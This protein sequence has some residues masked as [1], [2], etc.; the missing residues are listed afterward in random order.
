M[1]GIIKMKLFSRIFTFILLAAVTVLAQNE[2]NIAFSTKSG[3]YVR[4]GQKI[5]FINNAGA[6]TPA[7]YKVERS[8]TGENNWKEIATVTSP[9]NEKEFAGSLEEW[10]SYFSGFDF[11][12]KSGD[13][14]KRITTHKLLDSLYFQANVPAVALACGAAYLDKDADENTNYTYKVSALDNNKQVISSMLSNSVK[15]PLVPQFNEIVF[16]TKIKTSD[17]MFLQWSTLEGNSPAGFKVVRTDMNDGTSGEVNVVKGFSSSSGKLMMNVKDTLLKEDVVYGY[18]LVPIDL[19][20]NEGSHTQ[21]VF[22]GNYNFSKVFIS[23]LNAVSADTLFSINLSWKTENKKLAQSFEIYRSEYFDSAFVKIATI[24]TSYESYAD[25]KVI[26]GKRYYYAIKILGKTG[27]SSPLSVK[28]NGMLLSKIKPITPELVEAKGTKKGVILKLYSPESYISGFYIYRASEGDTIFT[29]VSPLVHA[30]N[31]SAVYE[32]TMNLSGKAQYL[33]TVKSISNGGTYSEFSD[34]LIARPNL[35]VYVLPPLD[36]DVIAQENYIK[37]YWKDMT[38][39]DNTISG[40][41]VYRRAAGKEDF[42]QINNGILT[43]EQNYFVDSSAV[44]GIDYEYSVKCIDAYNNESSLSLPE[45]A[46]IEK[47]KPGAP[48]VV[49]TLPS[50]DGII[51]RWDES[52]QENIAAYKIYRYQRG[53]APVL[54]AEVKSDGELEFTDKQVKKGGLYFYYMTVVNN[55]GFESTGGNET[56]IRF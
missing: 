31:D 22:A 27:E 6:N 13:L 1:K 20:G 46:I 7:Y 36:V 42:K 12:L 28:I 25:S 33:Y 24:D 48:G 34:T 8:K 43:I 17:G 18:E 30:I 51:L 2:G 11:E 16:E 49:M 52:L 55:E 53:S 44:K 23:K 5:P 50:T 35:P 21:T 10:N 41:I 37:V 54:V 14:W 29:L 3:I 56:A 9:E 26:P 47:Q 4:F 40:Y 19:F 39:I 15:Y 38:S 45:T 32:D